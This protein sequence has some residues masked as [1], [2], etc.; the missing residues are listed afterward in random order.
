MTESSPVPTKT[1]KPPSQADVAALA[2]VSS[3]TVSRVANNRSN[4]DEATRQRVLSAMQL[5]GYQPNSAARALA[6][7]RF[8]MIGVISFSLSAH[9]NSRT[10][11]AISEV[12]RISGYSVNLVG[13]EVAT[14][15]A[16]EQAV[17]KLTNQ[18]V[19]GIILIE[20]Q[21]LDHPNR[22]LPHGVPL[23]IADGDPDQ[24]H[25]SVDN[26]QAAGAE[27]A[28]AHLLGLGHRTVH[29]L[30]GPQ[31]SHS[32]R[33]RAAAWFDTLKRAG[34]PVPPVLYGDWSAESGYRLGRRLAADPEV[35]AVFVA[36]DHMALGLV[37]ALHEAGRRVPHDVSVVG[38]D[39]VAESAFFLPPL[40][41]VHQ[42]FEQVGRLCVSLLLEQIADTGHR[43]RRVQAVVTPELVVRESTAP[44]PVP[45]SR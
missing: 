7:G 36:N 41:T 35:T 5:L 29:H 45:Q 40:T 6:T 3:Q 14:G 15:G 12:A 38:F 10:L 37:K 13:P 27:A 9:G 34:A 22:N 1:R 8:G 11:Q 4:V 43:E 39:D 25:P 23:V 42:D 24:R 31:D 2:G 17:T 19:D 26:N 32:A 16:M 30:A 20:A 21:I 44:P 28:T 18:G 33:R